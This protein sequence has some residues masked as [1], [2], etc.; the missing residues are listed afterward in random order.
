M[1]TGPQGTKGKEKEG[2]PIL[3]KRKKKE[4]RIQK[5]GKIKKDQEKCILGLCK[6]RN[7]GEE[8]FKDLLNPLHTLLC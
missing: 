7:K 6:K 4:K 2:L 8:D 1:L 3:K 5:E